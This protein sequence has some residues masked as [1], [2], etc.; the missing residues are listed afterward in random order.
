MSDDG[1]IAGRQR[2]MDQAGRRGQPPAARH[3]PDRPVPAPRPRP[4]H[5]VRRDARRARRA[6]ARREGPRDR[7]LELRGQAHRQV[8]RHLRGQGPRAKLVSAQNNYSLLERSV[9]PDVID[10]CEH[11]RP[12][13]PSL[14]P[15]RVRSAH[16]QVHV[17][18]RPSGRHA[19]HADGASDA[20]AGRGQS[21]RTRTSRSSTSSARS[22]R[23]TGTRCSSS[24]CRG[25]RR[26]R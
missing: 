5:A 14:L 10:A 11:V 26:S 20:R 19:H 13:H 8:Q 23:S 15:T 25:S 9:E 21:S 7:L 17:E 4:R 1:P 18:G 6:R 12:R 16:R 3:R 22:P 2:A 24:R